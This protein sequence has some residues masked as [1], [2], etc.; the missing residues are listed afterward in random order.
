MG[1]TQEPSR[2][3]KSGLLSTQSL[4]FQV[5]V[6]AAAGQ[7]GQ[8]YSGDLLRHVAAT[9]DLLDMLDVLPGE[10]MDATLAHVAS[11]RGA[12][13]DQIILTAVAAYV[14]KEPF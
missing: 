11:E 8:P 3:W 1:E 2:L 9:D 12:E 13:L 10:G 7:E 5:M 4:N 6:Q 14:P